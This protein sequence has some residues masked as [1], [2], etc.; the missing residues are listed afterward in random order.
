[1]KKKL[2]IIQGNRTKRPKNKEKK[3]DERMDS[4]DDTDTW[5]SDKHF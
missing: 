3:T 2:S 4:L 5:S 1:M